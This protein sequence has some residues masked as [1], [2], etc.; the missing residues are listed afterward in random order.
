MFSSSS[1]TIGLLVTRRQK[2]TQQLGE[3]I[4]IPQQSKIG[5]SARHKDFS[6]GGV[7]SKIRACCSGLGQFDGDGLIC[8]Q[9]SSGRRKADGRDVQERR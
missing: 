3:I 7:A 2:V 4:S 1:L 5:R 8:L 9:V 6:G